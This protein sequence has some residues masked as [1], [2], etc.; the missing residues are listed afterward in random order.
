MK[1]ILTSLFVF[2]LSL[3]LA[4]AA[5]VTNRGQ[6]IE[7]TTADEV[8]LAAADRVNPQDASIY[9]GRSGQRGTI[10]RYVDATNAVIAAGDAQV[11]QPPVVIPSNAVVIGGFAQVLERF[12]PATNLA[13]LGFATTTDI[14]AA[15]TNLSSVAGSKLAVVPV[16][17]VGTSVETATNSLLN[18]HS[19][20]DNATFTAGKL[21]V[22][23][24][25]FLAQ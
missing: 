5:T 22:V 20:A 15:T 9:A 10:V 19:D 24:D 25:Y 1:K 18:L 12:L 11:M 6:V 16:W 4:V 21:M 14:L 13:S 2:A 23:L 8:A 7:I 17:T 3:Q